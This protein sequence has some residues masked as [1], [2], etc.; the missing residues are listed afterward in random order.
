MAKHTARPILDTT[1]RKEYP[2]M[3]PVE[4][5]Q[6]NAQAHL[7]ETDHRSEAARKEGNPMND[8]EPTVV[9][10]LELIAYGWEVVMVLVVIWVV[11]V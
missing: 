11:S 3:Y 8:Y 4:G 1:T 10:V 6:R 7:Q 2:S 5:H 9:V